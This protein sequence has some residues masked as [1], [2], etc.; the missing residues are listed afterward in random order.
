MAEIVVPQDL[1]NDRIVLRSLHESDLEPYLRAF[2]DDPELGRLLGIE[3]DPDIASLRGRLERAPSLLAD[4]RFLELAIAARDSDR[5]LGTLTLHSF[6]WHS[7]RAELGFWV[8]PADRRQGIVRAAITIALDWMFSELGLTRVEMTTTPD[9]IPVAQLAQSLGFIR[10]G[11]LRARNLERGQRVD[12]DY[13]GLLKDEH[14][15]PEPATP[16]T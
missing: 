8:T 10:E 9:N 11:R 1:G 4:G 2:A 5:L 13:F 15:H 14:T 3:H 16:Q 6:D 7:E 12:V